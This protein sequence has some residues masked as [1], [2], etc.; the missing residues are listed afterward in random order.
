MNKKFVF[1]FTVMIIIG[2]LC[3][4]AHAAVAPQQ[5]AGIVADTDKNSLT[6][7]K[8]G[9]LQTWEISKETQVVGGSIAKNTPVEVTYKMVALK[10]EVK[11]ELPAE[12]PTGMPT[13]PQA[14]KP[15]AGLPQ[16]MRVPK[17]RSL[18][19]ELV[20][21][22]AEDPQNATFVVKQQ[23]KET[24]ETVSLDPGM[25]VI[26]YGSLDMVK[27]GDLIN[28]VYEDKEGKKIARTLTIKP[29]TKTP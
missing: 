4:T 13:A 8:D 29:K 11:K 5:A 10:V 26:K 24:S 15:P 28:L 19:G 21:L 3:I 22:D 23:D 9:A 18:E 16:E 2:F 27:E 12:K 14:G 17:I 1:I 6:I 25:Q 7:S 20:S